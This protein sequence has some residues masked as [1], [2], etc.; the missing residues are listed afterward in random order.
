MCAEASVGAAEGSVGGVE[1]T[2]AGS[3]LVP[4]VGR[5]QIAPLLEMGFSN[6]QAVRALRLARGDVHAAAEMILSGL[7]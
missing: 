3:G 2:G 7:V 1:A 5:E 6:T 4:T